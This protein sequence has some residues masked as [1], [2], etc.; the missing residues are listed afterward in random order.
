MTLTRICIFVASLIGFFSC[1]ISSSFQPGTASNITAT[2]I[3]IP[4]AENRVAQGPTNLAIDFTEALRDYYQTN[5]KLIVNSNQQSDLEL[6]TTI[7]SFATRQV[8]STAEAGSQAEQMELTVGINIRYI[9]NENTINSIESI[10]V[11]Q[12]MNYDAQFTLEEAQADLLPEII[13]LLSQDIFNKT[14]A[15]W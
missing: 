15:R 13:Q 9:D 1:K 2:N 8:S 14:I 11:Q 12:K 7:T 6:Y 4:Q 5:S 3:M 10:T